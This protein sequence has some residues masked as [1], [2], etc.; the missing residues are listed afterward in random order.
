MNGLIN[1]KG[2][3]SGPLSSQLSQLQSLYPYIKDLNYQTL[4]QSHNPNLFQFNQQQSPQS[5]SKIP[6]EQ[7]TPIQGQN[8]KSQPQKSSMQPP[9]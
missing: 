1:N 5:T 9:N 4:T 8:V 3:Y 2:I 6:H 7:Q